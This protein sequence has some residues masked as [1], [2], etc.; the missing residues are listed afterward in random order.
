MDIFNNKLKQDIQ[1]F[2]KFINLKKSWQFGLEDFDHL[3]DDNKELRCLGRKWDCYKRTYVDINRQCKNKALYNDICFQCSKN[4]NWLGKVNEYPDED[5]V[6]K[7]YRKFIK[8]HQ[9][10]SIYKNRKI[11]DEIDLNKYE[12]YFER[13]NILKKN[14]YKLSKMHPIKSNDSNQIKNQKKKK[15]KIVFKKIANNKKIAKDIKEDN[16]KEQWWNYIEKIKIYDNEMLS[17]EEFAFEERDNKNVLLNKNEIILGTFRYWID[18]EDKIPEYYKNYENKVLNPDTN[19]PLLE[20]EL[21][22]NKSMYHNLNPKIYREYRY[23]E[24]TEQMNY[25]NNVTFS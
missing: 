16:L 7:Y 4:K 24:N 20:Y 3:F 1:F 11:E 15:I 22:E 6:L 21:F 19:V 10:L 13:K 5:N 25:T 12:K 9:Y 18:K 2:V 8:N 14:K 17:S 23:D